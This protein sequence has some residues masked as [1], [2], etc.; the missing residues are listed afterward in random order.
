M[1]Y[2]RLLSRTRGPYP[3]KDG[4]L[5][6][7]V[8]SDKHWRAFGKLIGK[9]D[10]VDA[11]ERFRSQ[12]TRTT[13]AEDVGRL[14]SESLLSRTNREWLEVLATAD[15]PACPVNAVGD[16]FDDP[17]LTAVEFFQEVDHPTEGRLKISRPPVRFSATP[18]SVRRLAPN[19]GEHD[20]EVLG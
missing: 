15:I 12:Q 18:A 6:I 16:L 14:L 8:Y 4:H 5:A 20:K 13:Y 9:P 19:L 17:H 10:I 2:K 11:D 3:T 7:V 1:G